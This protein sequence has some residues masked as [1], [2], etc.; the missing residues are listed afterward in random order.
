MFSSWIMP[1]PKE[2][3]TIHCCK[4]RQNT[5]AGSVTGLNEETTVVVSLSECDV[6][7]KLPSTKFYAQR[8][9]LLLALIQEAPFCHSP[10]NNDYRD[11]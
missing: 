11:S 8:I 2:G 4:P 10:H 3:T 5:L 6:A 9:N 7:I 1:T